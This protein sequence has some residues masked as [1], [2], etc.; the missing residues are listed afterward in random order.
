MKN[1]FD[2]DKNVFINCPFDDDYKPFF[3]AIVFVVHRCGFV[4]RCSLE[5]DNS[6]SI[7]IE[8]IV[9]LIRES[10]Y[11]IHDLSR[12]TLDK[13][14]K[15]PRFNMPL[16]LGLCLGAIK[17]GSKRQTQNQFLIIESKRFRFQQFI[18]DLSGQDIRAHE[19]KIEDAIKVVRNWLSSKTEETIPSGKHIFEEYNDFSNALPSLCSEIKWDFE[20]LT[21]KEYT[22]LVTNWLSIK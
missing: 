18:S 14:S 2:Y 22:S 11:S 4:L 13:K 5:Y 21:F 19:N 6:S 17:F 7:R 16:E 15:L 1:T 8:N 20:N 9:Q 12:V 10:K 3:Y